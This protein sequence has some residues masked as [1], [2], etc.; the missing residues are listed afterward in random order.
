MSES[1]PFPKGEGLSWFKYCARCSEGV[2]GVDFADLPRAD[3]AGFDQQ[4]NDFGLATVS[5]SQG[6]LVSL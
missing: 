4:S 6:S 5:L 2:V 3:F 1:L